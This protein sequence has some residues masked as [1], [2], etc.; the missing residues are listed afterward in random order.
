VAK[1]VESTQSQKIIKTLMEIEEK[2]LR[3]LNSE[4]A[5]Y[6]KRQSYEFSE[7]D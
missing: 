3:R 6:V 5:E 7:K 2:N 1:D 4:L